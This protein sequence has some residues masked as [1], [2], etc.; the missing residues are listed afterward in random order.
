[1][2]LIDRVRDILMKPRET[3][4]VIAAEPAT[5]QSIFSG[6]VVP[7]A[8]IPA[9]AGFIG[10][11]LI[12]VGGFGFH[13]RLPI[14]YGV[15]RMIFSFGLTLAMVY[16]L[17]LIV[18]ALAP[19]FGGVK[20]RTAA[21]KLIAYSFTAA[22]VG[23]IFAIL[24]TLSF[25]ALL[26][27]CYSIY[28]L[29]IG[30]GPLMKCPPAKAGGYTAVVVLCGIVAAA[31]VSGVVGGVLAVFIG[32]SGVGI[33]GVPGMPGHLGDAGG[34]DVTIK[35]PDGSV[36]INP[37]LMEAMA[38]RMEEAG[39]RAEIAQRAGNSSQ[40]LGD[41]ATAISGQSA[42]PIAAAELKT[43]LP[44][45]IGDLKRESF[46]VQGGGAM[47]VQG[48]TANARYVNGDQHVELSIVDM[49]TFGAFASMA[50]W[51]NVTV[52]K[53]T[54]TG[55]EKV[56]KDGDSTIHET[57]RK[58]GGHSEISVIH[59]N[60]VMIEATGDKIDI[61]ALKKVIAAVDVGRLDALKKAAK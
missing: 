55:T 52:D 28:L 60:G 5:T 13:Y 6:Y 18:D 44:E 36:T 48:S 42:T 47:G 9:L 23:G 27:G 31:V 26:G 33:N 56:Y 46:E 34:G 21:L 29:F 2:N 1:M 17:A 25:L 58:D 54:E 22:F 16:V 4:P 15:L 43:L 49:G 57:A 12:G 10:L 30:I 24:P 20:D 39:K 8:A 59:G 53:E 37:S 50:N 38:K 3:W 41:M 32:T 51:A 19:T 40:A 61:G 14:L 11:S 45:A 7:L 35:T